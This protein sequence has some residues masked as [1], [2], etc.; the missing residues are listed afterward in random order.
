MELWDDVS[1]WYVTDVVVSYLV[2][3]MLSCLMYY[4]PCIKC[5]QLEC[6]NEYGPDILQQ[7]SVVAKLLKFVYLQVRN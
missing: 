4:E 1:N 6:C 3:K 7:E 5:S 2:N